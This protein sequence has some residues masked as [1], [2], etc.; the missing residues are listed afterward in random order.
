MSL[1]SPNMANFTNMS[2]N[3]SELKHK[4][5]LLKTSVSLKSPISL[6]SAILSDFRHIEVLRH[7]NF[8]FKSAILVNFGEISH[9]WWFQTHWG[10]KTSTFLLEISHFWWFQTHWGFK[11]STFLLDISHFWWFLTH[12]GF[13]TSTFLL[14]ISHF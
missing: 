3:F 4:Y 12:W 10:F 6:L 1:K 7:A 14:E 13:K 11:T 2:L 5:W 8:C 9:F